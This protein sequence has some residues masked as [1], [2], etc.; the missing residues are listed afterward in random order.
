METVPLV[1]PHISEGGD[2]AHVTFIPFSKTDP[3]SD[4]LTKIAS[5][6]RPLVLLGKWVPP[7]AATEAAQ[8]PPAGS[9]LLPPTQPA[10]DEP[11]FVHSSFGIRAFNQHKVMDSIRY[12]TIRFDHPCLLVFLVLSGGPLERSSFLHRLLPSDAA[13]STAFDAI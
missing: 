11:I 6:A 8:S 9:R 4:A 7:F 1:L 2:L 13:F 3:T 12:F 10:L 5:R